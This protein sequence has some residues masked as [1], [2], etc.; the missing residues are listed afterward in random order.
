MART[1]TSRRRERDTDPMDSLK[2]LIVLGLLGTIMYGAY[3][4]VQKGPAPAPAGSMV[5]AGST[6]SPPEISLPRDPTAIG[7][8]PAHPLAGAEPL[9]ASAAPSGAGLPPPLPAV[10]AQASALP[11]IGSLGES[12]PFLPPA[13]PPPAALDPRE[14]AI[15]PLAVAAAAEA[16]ALSAPPPAPLPPAPLPLAAAAP[17]RGA[18]SP[19]FASAWADAHEMLGAGRYAEALSVLSLW[20]DDASLGLEESQRL[21]DL[22]GQLAGTVIYSQKDL[23][24]PP[25]IVAPGDTL[26]SI[27][28][29]LQVP[30]QLLAK[31]NGVSDPSQLVQG[32]HLKVVRG[33]F[34][35]VISVSRRRMSLQ[36]GGNYAGSFPVV[37]GR[38]IYDR[39]G[40][41]V[42]VID[43]RRPGAVQEPIGIAAQVAYAP[44]TGPKSIILGE[45]LAIE[46]V[47]DPSL[48]SDSASASSVIV[49]L[50]DLEDIADIL[51]PGSQVLVRK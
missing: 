3:S 14:A 11:P 4:V 26:P 44:S 29:P 6:F 1:S 9:Q 25:H 36:V 12:T 40:Q 13:S 42:A 18:P 27:A 43:I 51:G 39:V 23:L 15:E 37:L 48:V 7:V 31:I 17:S 49:S 32:E 5:E 38:Q 22:L 30:W 28:A 24:L 2:P 45:G 19:A 21:E 10:A 8:A 20:H 41:S 34:D 50:R 46:G 35:A 16:G 47:E 33:P